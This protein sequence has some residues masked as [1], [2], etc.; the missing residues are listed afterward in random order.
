MT[1]SGQAAVE[2]EPH[3]GTPFGSKEMESN[4]ETADGGCRLYQSGL[5]K[6]VFF[7]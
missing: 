1:A 5:P 3:V 6:Q 7:K 2:A 4:A